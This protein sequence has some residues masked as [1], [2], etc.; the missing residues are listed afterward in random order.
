VNLVA[1]GFEIE[2]DMLIECARDGFSTGETAIDYGK[3]ADRSK[4]SSI[5]DGLNLASFL[6]KRWMAP[7][8]RRTL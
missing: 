8:G 7:G 3:G 5:R 2:A 4:L 1:Q 6:A